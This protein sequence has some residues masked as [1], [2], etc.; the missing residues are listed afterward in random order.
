MNEKLITK[1][2]IRLLVNQK[3]IMEYIRMTDG[4]SVDD[5]TDSEIIE[6][7]VESLSD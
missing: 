1:A 4:L 5:F 3:S 7:L 2:L 6:E